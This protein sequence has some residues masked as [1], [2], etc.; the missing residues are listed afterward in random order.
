[1]TEEFDNTPE[2]DTTELIAP[3]SGEK[4]ENSPSEAIQS[5]HITSRQKIIFVSVGCAVL[6]GILGLILGL[7]LFSGRNNEDDRILQNV[8]AAGIDLSGMTVEEATNALHLAT[9]NSL[10]NEPMVIHI[11]DGILSLEPD[12]TNAILDVEAVAQAAYSYGR[13]GNHSDDQQIRKNAHRRSYTIPLLPYLNLNLDFI[14]N[15]VDSYSSALESVYAEPS[16]TLIGTRPIYGDPSPN[17]QSMRIT[18][19][20]PL[21][22]LDSEDLYKQILDAYSINELLLE[23]E[24]PEII[25][26]SKLTA[27]E[28]FDQFCTP[29]QDASLDASTYKI[30][31]EIYGY[32]F[33]V[34]ALQESLDKCDP[35]DTLEFE[36]CFL[37][38]EILAEEINSGLF[39]ETIA[40]CTS[41]SS[42]DDNARDTNLQLSCNSINGYI[43][44]PGET[45]SFLK[46]L[47]EV[48][49]ESG[50][51][52]APASIYNDAVI[53]G[54]ISQTASALYYCA[55]HADLEI[56]ERH[57]HKYAADFIELGLDAYVN[58][59]STDLRFRNNTNIPIRIDAN[60]NRHTVTINLRAS[61]QMS[62]NVTLRTE[63]TAKDLPITSYQMLLPD[64]ING[65]QDGDIVVAGIEGYTVSVSKEKTD[66]TTGNL[67]ST[68]PVSASTYKKRD[69]IIARINEIEEDSATEPTDS[70]AILP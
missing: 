22:Q 54:G 9:D 37:V 17:H 53:G 26:P 27:Q 25:W 10:M 60:V 30:T 50:Y 61:T 24:T 35:G 57:N 58:G 59:V 13:S 7:L 11:Y 4:D 6:V 55:L 33:D 66:N 14:R 2:Y 34:A 38:P 39:Q 52:N 1:M 63:I 28:I 8:F 67:I 56:V 64:N 29:A 70:T 19:G 47:G 44:K 45:F 15:T 69:E 23:Y 3:K 43:I 40:T 32:G 62:Y 48:T 12:D 18:I 49:T 65:Y 21:R 51:A 46:V 20:T 31:P 42:L 5:F 16:I 36:L 41:G 68:A